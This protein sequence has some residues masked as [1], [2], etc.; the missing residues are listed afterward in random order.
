MLL[1]IVGWK[2][3]ADFLSLFLIITREIK[4]LN[5]S[6]CLYEVKKINKFSQCFIAT[7]RRGSIKLSTQ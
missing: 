3:E 4:L 2:N 6:K 1:S 7:F 5:I